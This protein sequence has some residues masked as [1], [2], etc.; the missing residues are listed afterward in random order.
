MA[1]LW[2]SRWGI[3]NW[4]EVGKKYDIY[5]MT[6][7]KSAIDLAI[8]FNQARGHNEALDRIKVAVK[9]VE[10]SKMKVKVAWVPGH[11]G[12]DQNEMADELAKALISFIYFK[13]A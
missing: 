11:A 8:R 4:E 1:L 9:I 7:C 12:V 5:I 6:D 13:S 2:L 3:N 10:K